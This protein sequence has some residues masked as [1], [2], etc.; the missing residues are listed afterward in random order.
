MQHLAFEY[1]KRGACLVVAARRERSLQ[2]VAEKAQDLGAPDVLVVRTDVSRVEDCR[3][4]VDRT[5]NHFGRCKCVFM[6]ALV[7]LDLFY[8]DFLMI[9]FVKSDF[10]KNL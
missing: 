10:L 3:N 4:V 9:D 7:Y 2:E 5:T 8:V 1:A 6:Y